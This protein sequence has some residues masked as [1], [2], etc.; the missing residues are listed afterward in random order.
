MGR[1]PARERVLELPRV[2]V[3]VVQ[4]ARVVVAL[5]EV[6]EDGAEDLRFLVRQRDPLAL[7]LEVVA[8]QDLLEEGSLGQH[9]LVR[10]K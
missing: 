3:L 4:Q 2:S 10:G 9:V 1:G 8:G 6:L 5:V 7:R